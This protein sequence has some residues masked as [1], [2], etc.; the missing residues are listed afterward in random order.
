MLVGF[1]RRCRHNTGCDHRA[2]IGACDGD[3]GRVGDF[4]GAVVD[5]VSNADLNLFSCC[6]VIE[7]GGINAELMAVAGE[8]ASRDINGVAVV[9]D[10][11]R[12]VARHGQLIAAVGIGGCAQQIKGVDLIVLSFC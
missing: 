4:S 11:R 2:V 10:G 5:V 1:A 7:G 9:I 6:E 3:G 12:A 8:S